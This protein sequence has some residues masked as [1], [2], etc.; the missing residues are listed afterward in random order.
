MTYATMQK[1]IAKRKEITNIMSI[2]QNTH[3]YK[4]KLKGLIFKSDS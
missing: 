3:K 2:E 4:T 1:K